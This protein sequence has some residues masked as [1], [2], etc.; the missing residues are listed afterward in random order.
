MNKNYK[1]W[2]E[3][4]FIKENDKEILRNY[5]DEEIEESFSKELKFGTAGIRGLMGL[6]SSKMNE[7]TIGKV[8]VGLANYLNK[9]FSNPSLVIAFDT[10]NN[11]NVY[12]KNVALILNYYGV[13]T[14]LFEKYTSTPEL[15]FAVKYLNCNS[16][17]VITSSHNPKDYNGYKV[18]NSNGGQI[19]YPEDVEIIE[20]VNNI[21]DFE[22]IKYAPSNNELF[23]VVDFDLHK[24]FIEENKK[25]II[26]KDLVI[27]YA[28]KVNVTYSSLHGVGLPVAETLLKYYGYKYNIVKEQCIYD[29]NFTTA[30]EP[31][32]EYEKN[33]AL[34]KNYAK[35]NNSDL[36]ILTDPDA[37]RIGVM[38][39][40]NNEYKLI[41]GNLLG[42]LFAD[43]IINNISDTNNSYMVKS[44]V[45]TPLMKKICET[46]NIDCY[47]VLTGCKNIANKRNNVTNKK[48]LFGY[49]ESLG[50]MFDINVNDK[51]GFSSM[52]VILEIMCYCKKNNILMSDY[53]D[54]LYKKYGYYLEETLSFV[55]NTPNGS[56]IIDNYM[57]DFR[58]N[59]IT[60]DKTYNRKDY[61]DEDDEL[62]TN[63]LKYL[64][65]DNSW[66]MIR[67]SGTEPKIKVYLG[68][69][70]DN[71]NKSLNM[72]ED[73]KK[74]VN[75]IFNK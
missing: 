32:P 40:K 8:T 52:L 26:N 36:I 10:R 73:M 49:E 56:S 61:L 74:F 67:P 15:S 69:T 34:S 11:S 22:M 54:N 3:N 57:N 18:Y 38:Y 12:A 25:A 45:T 5:T 44:I 65:S 20:E 1:E 24:A 17:I 27:N 31:N 28:P 37:D 33:Y 30:P 13:K 48:Y 42:V 51:N 58:N 46:S 4:K 47:D 63:A 62:N 50:Y 39:K 66:L 6:G 35:D 60:F 71:K 75:N 9:K 16:G 55:Y 70:S 23:N 7:Y 43:Y 14:Y 41:N 19:V 68:V 2:L 53:I 72:L 64:F 29:G 59:R 21:K